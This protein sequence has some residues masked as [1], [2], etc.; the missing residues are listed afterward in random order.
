MKKNIISLFTGM[1]A[2]VSACHSPEDVLPTVERQGITSLT[3]IFTNGKYVDKEIEKYKIQDVLADEYVIPIPWFYPENSDEETDENITAMRIRAEIANNCL[4][5]PPLTILDLTKNNYFTFTEPNGEK[6]KICIKGERIKSNKCEILTFDILSPEISGIIDSEKQTISL[7]TA[8]DLSACK[9]DYTL[10]AHATISPDPMETE[11]NLNEPFEFTV[12]AHD[13]KT[14][15]TYTVKKE[16]PDKIPYGFRSG[17]EK[18]LFMLDIQTVGFPW[19]YSNA[20]SLAVT[21]NNLIVCLGD[22]SAPEYLNRITGKKLGT[23]NIGSAIATGCVTSDLS[24][25][26]L[27]CSKATAGQTFSVYKMKSVTAIPEKFITFQNT[28]E[29]DMGTKVSVQGNINGDAMI[30]ATCDGIAGVS[31]SNKFIRWIVS[32]GIVGQSEIVEVNG[33]GVWGAPVSN[34]KVVSSGILPTDP[35]FL[36]YYDA[37]VLYCVDGTTNSVI[38]SITDT[39]NGNSWGMNNNCLDAKTFNGAKY[40]SLFC[41]SHFPH[42]G[43]DAALY[44]FDTSNLSNFSGNLNNSPALAFMTGGLTMNS[45]QE[46]PAATG[47]VLMVPSPDGYKLHVYYIDNNCRVMGAYEFDCIDK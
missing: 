43:M 23:L 2:L 20:P 45:S 39:N 17:S 19:T 27:I 9:A 6:R 7:I 37:N 44:L 35:Y 13:G 29:L 33:V 14:T 5:D 30:L 31:G 16:V 24:G 25:N 32:D 15:K 8:E 40:M 1:L 3:A 18:S 47:D 38:S 21:G 46:G 41:V 26:I 34:T 36:S 11:V 28:T 42:W 22:G 10:S 4:I 12:T